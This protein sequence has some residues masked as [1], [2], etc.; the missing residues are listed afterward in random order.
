[1]PGTSVSADSAP[2]EEAVSGVPGR[3]H[4]VQW[5]SYWDSLQT[6]RTSSLAVRSCTE[7]ETKTA[8]CWSL[9]G[10]RTVLC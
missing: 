3:L 5:G 7:G 6:V 8:E 2:P 10:L 9:A 4:P 1:M